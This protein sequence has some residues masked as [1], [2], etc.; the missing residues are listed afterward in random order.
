[1]IEGKCLCGR[2]QYAVEGD[3]GEVS[4]CHC[5]MCQRIHGAAFGTYGAVPRKNFRWLSGSDLVQVYQSSASMDR[6]F[7]S[8]CGSTLQA[9]LNTEPDVLYLALGTTNGDPK[10]RPSF[11]IFVGSKAPWYEIT[12]DLPQHETWSYT[13]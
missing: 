13:E 6:T 3:I 4:H 10:C 12:D 2:I 1:M 5:S 9:F 11:H 8:V 7:C